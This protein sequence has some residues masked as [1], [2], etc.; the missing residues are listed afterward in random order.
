M[1]QG[2]SKTTSAEEKKDSPVANVPEKDEIVRRVA[3]LGEKIKVTP[4]ARKIAKEF[5]VDLSMVTGTGPDGRI[6]REDVERLVKSST[7]LQ[8]IEK[9]SADIVP[10]SSMRKT[11][12]RRMTESFQSIPHFSLTVEVDMHELKKV[13]ESVLPNI[14][15][16]TGIRITYTDLFIKIVARAVEDN[17][18]INVSWAGDAMS[19]RRDID[20]GVAVNIENGLVVPVM[21][22]ANRKNLEEIAKS[23]FGSC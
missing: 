2:L 15:K 3:A 6:K 4:L 1:P 10:L 14:E 18:Q 7:P 20:I 19:M 23:R 12:A 22:E 16:R 21:K 5:S 17:P 9:K 11:I 8:K 13:R